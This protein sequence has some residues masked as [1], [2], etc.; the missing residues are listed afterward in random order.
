MKTLLANKA[1]L[2]VCD[3]VTEFATEAAREFVRIVD[4]SIA[5]RGRCSIALSGGS[6][7]GLL[8]DRLLSADFKQKVD[9][10][11]VHFFVSD[12]RCVPLEDEASNF[13]NAQRQLIAALSIPQENLHPVLT[14]DHT[15][16][17]S[18]ADYEEQLKEFFGLRDGQ[19]PQFDLLLLGMGPD[20]HTASLFPK[21]KALTET[22]R[23]V[24]ENFVD[25]LQAMRITFTFPSINHARNIIVLVQ[26][27]EKADVIREVFTDETVSYPVQQVKPITGKLEWIL[28]KT[29]AEQLLKVQ[30][31][32]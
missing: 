12:E 14:E 3:S 30:K 5:A 10:S 9:W 23:L 4:E 21:T 13:G 26:G 19:W 11:K 31:T 29:A 15:P 24:V 28:E 22:R 16:T 32:L 25:K 18:A 20:G 6:T 27:K 7:P 2:R 8:Y 1:Q 17:E